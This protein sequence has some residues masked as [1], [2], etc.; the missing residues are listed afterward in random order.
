MGEQEGGLY[1]VGID[2]QSFDPIVYAGGELYGCSSELAQVHIDGGTLEG[3]ISRS[4]YLQLD[5]EGL[6]A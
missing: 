3:K 6:I 4:Y 1:D 2:E 5:I